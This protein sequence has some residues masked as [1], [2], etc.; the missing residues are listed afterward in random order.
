MKLL[1]SSK[2]RCAMRSGLGSMVQCTCFWTSIG[3]WRSSHSLRTRA[4][5]TLTSVKVYEKLCK[6]IQAGLRPRAHADIASSSSAGLAQHVLLYDSTCCSADLKTCQT[7]R[8]DVEKAARSSEAC[9]ARCRSI[10]YVVPAA[11]VSTEHHSLTAPQPLRLLRRFCVINI[12]TTLRVKRALL[13]CQATILR[14][15]LQKRAH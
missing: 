2:S 15:W 1:T 7:L 3:M 13:R 6:T 4:R 9:A 11:R 5:T 12:C 14:V 8:G 10:A